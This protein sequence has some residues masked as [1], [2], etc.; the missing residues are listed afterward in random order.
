MHRNARTQLR[1]SKRPTVNLLDHMVGVTIQ[2]GKPH[3]CP[4]VK[5][6]EQQFHWYHLHLVCQIQGKLEQ[7][8][9][10]KRQCEYLQIVSGDLVVS[11][12]HQG[13]EVKF[14]FLDFPGA[15]SVWESTCQ[16]RGHRVNP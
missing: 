10:L 15:Y 14:F 3:G 4:W 16:C 2:W 5:V 9:L 6:R 11:E 13:V 8:L 1:S 7:T 12:K